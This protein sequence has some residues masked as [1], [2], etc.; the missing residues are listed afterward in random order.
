MWFRW[1]RFSF[2][3]FKAQSWRNNRRWSLHFVWSYV[4]WFNV[5]LKGHMETTWLYRPW[6]VVTTAKFHTCT[7][8]GIIKAYV[9]FVLL[10]IGN[11]EANYDS[12]IRINIA[13]SLYIQNK[14]WWYTQHWGGLAMGNA[15]KKSCVFINTR[16][17]L[18]HNLGYF[19]SKI[20]D[21]LNSNNDH[22]T[23]I[24]ELATF[25]YHS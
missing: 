3:N 6:R 25:I 1:F 8:G 5:S 18:K 20:L 7:Y 15:N 19:T 9:I 4:I 23:S 21:F 2:W 14:T 24:C 10:Y 22:T 11:Q 16:F 17:T 13:K 12:K